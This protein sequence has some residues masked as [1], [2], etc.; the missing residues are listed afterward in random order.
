MNFKT[1][2]YR[3]HTIEI[4]YDQEPMSPDEWGNDDLF[5]V[6]DHRQF[7]IKRDG[8]DPAEIAESWAENKS[9]EYD[10]YRVYPLYA[11]I[12]SGVSLSLGNSSYP[13]SCRW[14]TSMCGFVLVSLK[15]G[16]P[17]L[18][19]AV[20]GMVEEWNQYL[21]GEVYGY[22]VESIGESCWGFYGDH[23]YA[24]EEAKG[25]VDYH[26]QHEIKSHIAKVKQWIKARV[27]IQYRQPLQIA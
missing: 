18:D 10:G 11:Y 16:F 21:S 6:Y 4:D 25:T 23:E 26:I 3:G 5:I 7:T 2:E 8:F 27:P 1:I 9:N 13:F 20:Q 12:H 22:K 15:A 17:D 14:D 19:K 24:L